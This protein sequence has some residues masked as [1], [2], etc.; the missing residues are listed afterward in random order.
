MNI[1]FSTPPEC[2]LK[3]N[4][5][6]PGGQWL[7]GAYVNPAKNCLTLNK[8]RTLDDIAIMWRDEGDPRLILQKMTLKELRSSVWYAL[9]LLV[10]YYY[11]FVSLDYCCPLNFN[12]IFWIS[13]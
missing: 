13:L 8:Q 12:H 2:I 7:P 11:L 4:S 9:L 3:E 10:D 5:T 6:H 1:S